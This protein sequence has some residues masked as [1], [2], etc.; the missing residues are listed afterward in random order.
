MGCENEFVDLD[1]NWFHRD[2]IFYTCFYEKKYG[3]ESKF[4]NRK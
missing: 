1:N 3:N 4:N 2:W